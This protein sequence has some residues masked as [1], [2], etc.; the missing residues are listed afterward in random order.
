MDAPDSIGIETEICILFGIEVRLQ[1][2]GPVFRR[3]VEERTA[4]RKPARILLLVSGVEAGT[5]SESLV[6]D[7]GGE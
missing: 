3:G 7:G 2:S 4:D 1:P 5:K 6:G